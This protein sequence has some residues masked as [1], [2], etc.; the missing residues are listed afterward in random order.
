MDFLK[1]FKTRVAD[2]RV[3]NIE[4]HL[5]KTGKTRIAATKE[6]NDPTKWERVTIHGRYGAVFVKKDDIPQ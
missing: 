3:T 2:G 6:L 4:A 5:R 1:E